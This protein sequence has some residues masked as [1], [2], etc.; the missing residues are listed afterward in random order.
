MQSATILFAFIVV[1]PRLPGFLPVGFVGGT[2]T[3]G[4]R[5]ILLP[6]LA[7][8]PLL[9]VL[10]PRA[11][12]LEEVEIRRRCR[13]RR[14]RRR[15]RRSSLLRVRTAREREPANG[16]QSCGDFPHQPT[17]S[18]PFSSGCSSSQP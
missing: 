6:L 13:R 16:A 17:L 7:Y 5:A 9:V 12:I 11:E 18:L 8:E 15:R 4:A 14:L 10:L 1:V 3:F 2:F